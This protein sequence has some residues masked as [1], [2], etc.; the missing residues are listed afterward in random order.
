[1][2]MLDHF[3]PMKSKGI[4]TDPD[5]FPIDWHPHRGQALVRA[6]FFLLF[7]VFFRH[8]P[9]LT[10][11]YPPPLLVDLHGDGYGP[12]R[13]LTWEQGDLCCPRGAVVLCGQ[14]HRTR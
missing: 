1:M 12:A 5:S 4:E 9:S 7:S 13:G 8:P 10:P 2:L 14:W 3:G 11:V 6:I